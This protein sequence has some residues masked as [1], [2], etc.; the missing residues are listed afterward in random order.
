MLD[1]S[2]PNTILD[3]SAGL[4]RGDYSSVEL[5]THYLNQIKQN[6]SKINA[7]ITTCDEHSN[8]NALSWARKAD[9]KLATTKQANTDFLLGIPILHKDIFV[10][11]DILTTCGSKMLANFTPPYSA[12]VV[13]NLNSAGMI[14]LGKANL[15]EFAMGSSN[16]NSYFGAVKN[17]WNTEHV[18]GGSSG[19]SAAAVAMQMAPAATGTDT[20]GS[21]RQPA[22]FCNITGLKPTYGR[23]SRFG[24]IAYASSLDQAGP[25]AHTAE[26]CALL[27]NAMSGYDAKDSTSLNIP[28][29]DFT[30]DLKNPLKKLKI[31]IVKEFL[32]TDCDA[33][34]QSAIQSALDIFG[35]MEVDFLDIECPKLSFSIPAYYVLASAEAS[36]NLSRYDGIRYGYRSQDI[37]NLESLYEKTR[38]EA[39]GEEVKRRIMTGTYAL[40]S[41]YYDAYYIQA[42]KV[43]RLI[44]E[45]FKRAFEKVDILIAPT[46]PTT[47]F[48][49][50]SKNKNPIDMY[51]SDIYTTA[52]NL[53]G[54]PAISVPIGF[55]DGLPM[56]MQIIGP[57]MGESKI[58]NVAHQYQTKTDWHLQSPQI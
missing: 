18:P 51:L 32:S 58:L 8:Q 36:S 3:L 41:G 6:N 27:L 57:H 49:L 25:M 39:F 24:M 47:A 4:K 9:E 30:R 34:I 48:K 35:Q 33:N 46:T 53:A 1:N 17:P 40:S 52:V 14:T 42:Q 11:E 55:S 5:T 56:G 26:D 13:E 45:D 10:T 16:E 44:T 28:N 43:R 2:K 50:N 19:G 38:S 29:E 23:C 12:T 21:I 31:G 37:K 7:V 15:D 20:G 22:A 54:L